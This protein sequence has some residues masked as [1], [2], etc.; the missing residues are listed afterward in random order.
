[1]QKTSSTGGRV[2]SFSR[3]IATTRIK[4]WVTKLQFQR[5]RLTGEQMHHPPFHR[6]ALWV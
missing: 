1:M 3:E 6:I 5:G 2:L 4:G